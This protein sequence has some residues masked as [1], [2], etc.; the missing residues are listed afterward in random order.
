MIAGFTPLS[1]EARRGT[2]T[3][4]VFSV[5][6]PARPTALHEVPLDVI[7]VCPFDG[8]SLRSR[9]ARASGEEVDRI[10]GERARGPAARGRGPVGGS[11]KE[12]A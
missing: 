5:L 12:P 11:G 4:S 7:T 3:V 8:R 1:V 2:Q 6:R 9:V 10:E